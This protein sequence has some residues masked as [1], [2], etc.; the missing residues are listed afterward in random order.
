MC[1]TANSALLG[2]ILAYILHSTNDKRGESIGFLTL[3]HGSERSSVALRVVFCHSYLAV[4]R[5]KGPWMC[6]AFQLAQQNPRVQEVALPGFL[7]VMWLA[8]DERVKLHP[9][10]QWTTLCTVRL[11][12]TG[13]I[14]QVKRLIMFDVFAA[15]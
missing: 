4:R 11:R 3:A 13:L 9:C 7:L 12:Q 5:V 10:Q 8:V 1:G 15:V 6:T 2:N 14:P